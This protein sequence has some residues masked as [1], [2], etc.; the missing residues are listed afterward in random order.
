MMGRSGLP[1]RRFL[2]SALA[3]ALFYSPTRAQSGAPPLLRT[4]DS[5]FVEFRPAALAPPLALERIDG[6]LIPLE[7]FRGKAVLLCIWATWCPP[8]RRELPLLERLQK[9]VDPKKLEI[10][11][12]SVDKAGKP[13]VDKFLK[14]VNVRRLDTY[15]DSQGR[16]ARHADQESAAPFSLYGM[17]I[18]YVIDRGGFVMGYITGEVDWTSDDALA[19]LQHFMDG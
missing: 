8:C 11:T 5:Q 7:G 17:P 14:S 3:G 2:L 6:K 19:F 1:S 12:V 13:A 9:I 10:V 4:T 18:T 15:L 16:I